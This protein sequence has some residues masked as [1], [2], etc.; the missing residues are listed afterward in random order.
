[1]KNLLRALALFSI[2]LGF[3]SGCGGGTGGT[4]GVPLSGRLIQLD[5][6]PIS[7]ATVSI[8]PGGFQ[9]VT[10]S[11]GEFFSEVDP[12]QEYI[13]SVEKSG[14]VNAIV[15][16]AAPDASAG[17]VISAVFEAQNN[18]EV[19]VRVSVQPEAPPTPFPTPPAPTFTPT[20]PPTSTPYS[21]PTPLTA[22][23]IPIPTNSPIP[24]YSASPEP[25]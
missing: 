25:G 6:M 13:V 10:D 2:L 14:G 4:G 22:T 19:V 23:A 24:T 12:G 16:F 5:G 8:E 21:T 18:A 1:M 17:E 15:P 3:P 20:A 11:N 7:E 9:A